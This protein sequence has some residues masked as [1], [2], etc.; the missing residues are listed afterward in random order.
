MQDLWQN[1]MDRWIRPFG[2]ALNGF[3][4]ILMTEDVLDMAYSSCQNSCAFSLDVFS[5]VNL[6][7]KCI[8][9]SH[10]VCTRSRQ[11]KQTSLS[12][13][14]PFL[15]QM[16]LD[17]SPP[18]LEKAPHVFFCCCCFLTKAPPGGSLLKQ[19]AFPLSPKQQRHE[20]S[21]ITNH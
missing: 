17:L 16:S 7:A 8:F 19:G 5:Y 21:V 6:N 12:V 1:K 14:V 11:R 18:H 4:H 3:L 13:L 15:F 10:F 2:W 20:S 9:P